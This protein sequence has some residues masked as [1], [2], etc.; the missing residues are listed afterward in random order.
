MYSTVP[1]Q[2]RQTR[3]H[4][5]LPKSSCTGKEFS[6]PFRSRA[7]GRPRRCRGRGSW[8]TAS[9]RK[10]SCPAEI[11]E[12]ESSGGSRQ[13]W[14]ST[15]PPLCSSSSS[16]GSRA[17]GACSGWSQTWGEQRPWSAPRSS[18]CSLRTNTFWSSIRIRPAK[19]LTCRKYLMFLL[20]N[21]ILNQIQ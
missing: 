5:R 12:V 18:S 17:G 21:Q 2:N 14:R 3:H 19:I 1:D 8:R 13:P 16:A 9:R 20:H 15:P 10:D 4:C 7:A 11:E 6:E